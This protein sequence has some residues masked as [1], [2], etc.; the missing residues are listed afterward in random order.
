M[1]DDIGKV[2]G[3]I[4]SLLFLIIF[5]PFL[6]NLISISS[7]SL[8]EQ[9]AQPYIQTIQQKDAE[10]SSLRN[11]LAQTNTSLIQLNNTYEKLIGENIT[12]N[13]FEEMKI[14]LNNT[15]AQ[16]NLLNQKFE[17]VNTNFISVYNQ[18][19][20]YFSVSVIVNVFFVLFLI[21][22]I[23]SASIFEI[24]IKKKAIDWIL[25]KI[26]RKNKKAIGRPPRLE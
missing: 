10:I 19:F 12:K 5:V 2:I 9:Q 18:M 23:I 17:I 13:D 8:R 25:N 16:I 1:A 26:K 21:G 20:S 14:S 15:Q 7:D 4:I 24:D 11:Q 3:T 22:D 6:I